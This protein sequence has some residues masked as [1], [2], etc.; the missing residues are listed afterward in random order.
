VHRIDNHPHLKYTYVRIKYQSMPADQYYCI[1]TPMVGGIGCRSHSNRN[2]NMHRSRQPRSRQRNA[3]CP[4]CS[5]TYTHTPCVNLT[6]P[7]IHPS[8][9]AQSDPLIGTEPNGMECHVTLFR[10]QRRRQILFN[11]IDIN[12]PNGGS[13]NN[14]VPPTS[15]YVCMYVLDVSD[16]MTHHSRSIY[17]KR[18]HM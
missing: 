5:H 3:S 15:M 11:L 12:N 18:V 13:N 9:L 14:N 4:Q 17:G 10:K 2:R 6:Y 7:S 8:W 16:A 1:D